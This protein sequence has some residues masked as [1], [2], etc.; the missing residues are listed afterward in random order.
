MPKCV[1]EFLVKVTSDMKGLG[2]AS[3]WV[4]TASGD[5]E[6]GSEC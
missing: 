3:D 6:T 5:E 1:M 4:S 2:L